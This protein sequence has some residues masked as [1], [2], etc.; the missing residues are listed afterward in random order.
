ME[1]SSFFEVNSEGNSIEAVLVEDVMVD[2]ERRFVIKY[3]H[4]G[5]AYVNRL[6]AFNYL[7]EKINIICEPNDPSEFC[8]N[9]FFDLYLISVVGFVLSILLMSFSVIHFINDFRVVN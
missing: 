9:S 7:G 8:V 3:F 5:K 2:G 6:T 1:F 4:K